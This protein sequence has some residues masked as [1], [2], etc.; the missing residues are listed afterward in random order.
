M[1][2]FAI[3]FIKLFNLKKLIMMS[4][5]IFYM[6]FG[7][8]NN[9]LCACAILNLRDNDQRLSFTI[10]F[11]NSIYEFSIQQFFILINY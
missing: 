5:D 4:Y 10:I 9:V 11:V 2:L 8:L 7:S 3:F 1:R 6:I